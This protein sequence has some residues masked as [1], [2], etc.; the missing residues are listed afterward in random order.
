MW[1]VIYA[2]RRKFLKNMT[3]I[4]EAENT[5][6]MIV[7]HSDTHMRTSSCEVWITLDIFGFVQSVITVAFLNKLPWK[8]VTNVCS[9]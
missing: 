3:N 4:G 7:K 8:R 6:K 1:N 9:L 2:F 5:E